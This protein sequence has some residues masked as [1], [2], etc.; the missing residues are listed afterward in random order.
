MTERSAFLIPI[1]ALQACAAPG[2]LR[3]SAA[4][5][6]VE[7]AAPVPQSDP[8]ADAPD[9]VEIEQRVEE[10]S[11]PLRQVHDAEVRRRAEEPASANDS[12]QGTP[13]LPKLEHDLR[14]L[15]AGYDIPIDV[16]EAVVRYIRLFQSPEVRP[17][18]VRWL[19]RSHRY[20]PRFREILREEGLPEDTVYLAMVESGF[21][22]LA[23]S[24][25]RAVGAWQFIAATGKRFGLRQDFWVDERRDPEKAARAA[26][27]FLKELYLQHRD[28]RLAWAAYNAGPGKVSRARKLG[29]SGF[30]EMARAKRVLPAETRAYVPK[31]MAAAIIAKHPEAFGFEGGEVEPERWVDYHEVVVPRTTELSFVAEAARVH[32]DVLLDLNPELRRTCTPPRPYRVKIPR[33]HAQ[34]FAASWPR[35][36]ERAAS[37]AVARHQVRRGETLAAIA[38]AYGVQPAAVTALN[39][40]RSRRLRAGT[41]LVIPLGS[42][43][44]REAEALAVRS[45]PADGKVRVRRGDSLWSI[46][47]RHGVT[48]RELARWNGIRDPERDALRAGRVLT[49]APRAAAAARIGRAPTADHVK[50]RPTAAASSSRKV[51][52]QPGD[53]LWSLARRFGVTI[54]DLAEWNGIRRPHRH[55]L[56]AGRIL[57]VRQ[58]HGS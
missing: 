56:H 1:V 26:A 35:I 6:P 13:V 43:P 7:I 54:R 30:W 58:R 14:R 10:D 44:R 28:W 53:S 39:K 29:Y 48:V 15:Q 19:A 17:H 31:I 51:R 36:A 18:F 46:A 37:T 20:A 57:V 52:V 24:R 45:V 47:R 8:L 38:R 4:R 25:A 3:T 34:V 49:V 55:T 9:D 32:V 40:L 42:V 16:N 21:A 41:V 23:T 12:E 5:P 22:N 27:R 33:D 11:A 2:S 50:R